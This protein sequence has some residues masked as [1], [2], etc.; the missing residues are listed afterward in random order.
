[1]RIAIRADAAT[2]IGIGHVMRCLTLANALKMKGAEVSFVC[3]PFA[4]HL[5]ERIAAEG[6]GLYLLPLPAQTIKPPDQ[7]Q[8]PPHAAWL[9]ESWET[10]LAQTQ[11]ALNGKQFDWLIVDHYSLDNRW[12]NEMHKFASKIMVIDDLADRKHECDV[13]LDQNIYNNIRTRYDGFTLKY[14]KR[15]LGP[16]YA[17]LRLEFLEA[18][19]KMRHRDGSIKKILVSFGGSDPSNETAKVIKALTFFK[20]SGIVMDV[21]VGDFNKEKESIK[22]LCKTMPNANFHDQVADMACFMLNADFAFGGSGV[23]TWERLA[24]GLP[25]A[26]IPIAENQLQIACDVAELGVI[27]N[28]GKSEEVTEEKI[29]DFFENLLTDPKNLVSMS[30]KAS[31]LIDARGV[32]RV[33]QSLTSN[34]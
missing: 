17:L 16:N 11:I 31:T 2:H 30:A 19:K 4:G 13:L 15:L 21:I 6:H 32:E 10:D 18:R 25:A 33:V 12:E 23:S 8:T 22:K 24:M 27:H 28:L 29:K 20:D 3:R 26:V 7:K 9:G 5:G 34:S 14:C 1:M